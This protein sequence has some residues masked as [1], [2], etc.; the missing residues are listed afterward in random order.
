M[1]N[2]K[3]KTFTAVLGFGNEVLPG[4]VFTTYEATVYPHGMVFHSLDKKDYFLDFSHIT[5]ASFLPYT[6]ERN[7]WFTCLAD[8]QHYCF[9]ASP[10]DWKSASGKQLLA[11]IS[12][13][14]KI[15]NLK[16]LST[17]CHDGLPTVLMGLLLS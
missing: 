11:G 10:K 15:Q 14:H 1:T 16:D 7:L 4:E 6:F 17:Y 5:E 9:C 12:H 13:Y 3:K 2:N 8:G